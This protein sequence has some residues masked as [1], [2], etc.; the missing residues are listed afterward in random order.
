MAVGYLM[1]ELFEL[2]NK[3]D[4]EVF[5]YY[6]G[7]QSD[8][9]LN[10]RLK[11]TIEHWRDIRD[12]SDD[13]AAARVAA[14]GIDILVDVNG[15]TRDS[16]T[17]C[18]RAG[19]RR[20][21]VNWLG[22]PGTM[23]SPYHHYIIADDWI[24]PPESEIYYSEKVL[25]LP[26]YQP[27]DRKRQVA[28]ETPTRSAA[29]L[30]EN[31]FVFCCF[32]GTHKISRFSFERWLEILAHVPDSVL[33]LLDTSEQTKERLRNFA[34]QKDVAGTRVIFAPKMPNANHHARYC[35]AD[36][37][38]DFRALWRAHHGFGRLVDGCSRIDTFGT[39]FRFARLR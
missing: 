12:L 20:S 11:S 24:I 23:G 34:E 32:N 30:P 17:A 37:F 3:H 9:P 39:Q 33:W 27:N 5:A 29:G 4:V 16:K 1:A 10:K 2:H 21:R 14:D 28:V 36:L 18:S 22:Y 13:E 15:H 26:C 7:P 35:L 19:P 38:L 8:S 25:R 6:C 31:A